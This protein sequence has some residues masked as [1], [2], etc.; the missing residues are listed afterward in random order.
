VVKL[1]G[2]IDVLVMCRSEGT[3]SSSGRSGLNVAALVGT[4]EELSQTSRTRSL[5]REQ[6][7][8]TFFSVVN[9]IKSVLPLMRKA[10]N[11]HIIVLTGISE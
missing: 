3:S 9:V 5:I 6:F 7:E 2:R 8:T 11:G 10:R 1:F 4:I